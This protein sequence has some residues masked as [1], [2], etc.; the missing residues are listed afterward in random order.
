M[1]RYLLDT[2]PLTAFLKG[3]DLATGLIRNWVERGQ[4]AT[5]ILVYGEITEFYRSLSEAD[6]RQVELRRVM[7]QI[8]PLP[9]D[10]GI[11]KRYADIRLRLRPP[12]GSGLIGDIDTLIAATALEHGLTMVTADSDFQRVPDLDVMLVPRKM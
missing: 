8:D 12:H 6:R 1:R 10:Y 3:R 9:L 2:T 7:G 5:S 4:A 11:M